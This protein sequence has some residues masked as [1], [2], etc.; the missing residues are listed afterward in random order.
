MTYAMYFMISFM[1]FG[2]YSTTG[3]QMTVTVLIIVIFLAWEIKC[4]NP[5]SDKQNS[6]VRFINSIEKHK[7]IV[8]ALGEDVDKW[9]YYQVGSFLQTVIW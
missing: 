3:R 9:T 7:W 4:P 2:K 5:S 6:G 1:S 8:Q